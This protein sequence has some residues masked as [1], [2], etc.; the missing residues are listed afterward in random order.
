MIKFKPLKLTKKDL[1]FIEFQKLIRE[2]IERAFI[3]SGPPFHVGIRHVEKKPKSLTLVK[4]KF[5]DKL[6]H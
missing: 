2:Q 4:M 3:Y 1:E 5:W 6:T